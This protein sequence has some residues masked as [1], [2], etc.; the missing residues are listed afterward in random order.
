MTQACG[1]AL[2]DTPLGCCGV[3]WSSLG[4]LG[5]QLPEANA[6]RT[7]E[8]LLRRHGLTQEAKPPA[9]VA[10]AMHD[11][12]RLMG[13]Q[14]VA[15]QYVVLDL[16]GVAALHRRV[17]ELTRDIPAGSTRT[18]GNIAAQLGDPLLARA[19]GQALAR[20]PIAVIVPCHRVLAAGGRSGGFSAGGGVATKLKLLQIEGAQLSTQPDLF[21]AGSAGAAAR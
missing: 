21:G 2:F 7:R 17:Y 14:R 4:I 13:G 3:A 11:V 15:L 6:Q 16:D 18:Y 10:Q 8:R 9:A 19:V 5:L 20:N 12:T 1:A